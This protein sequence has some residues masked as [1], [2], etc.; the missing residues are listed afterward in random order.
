MDMASVMLMVLFSIF[1][2][3]AFSQGKKNTNIVQAVCGVLL[4]VYSYVVPGWILILLVGSALTF[5]AWF[6]RD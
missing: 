3:I 1:G 5:V 6:F 4:M 2:M